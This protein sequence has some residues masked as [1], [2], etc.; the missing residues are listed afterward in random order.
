MTLPVPLAEASNPAE[1]GGKCASL[2]RAI[3]AELPVPGGFALSVGT[4]FAAVEG[5]PETLAA[6]EEVL[7]ELEGPVAVRSSAIGEDDQATSFAGQH[8]TV[9]NVRTPGDLADA[10]AEVYQSAH[11]ASALAYRERMG[12]AGAPR[13]GVV[14]QS[15]VAAECAG[16]LFTHNPATGADERLI[17][18]AWGLG[19]VVVSGLV[20]P[21]SYRIS[22]DGM[23]LERRAGR[24]HMLLRSSDEGGIEEVEVEPERVNAH[25]LDDGSLG[26]LHALAVLCEA[27]Y[28]PR[29][30]IEWAFAEGRLYLLQC[31]AITT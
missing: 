11:S 24:K 14:V 8:A 20:I 30:D 27:E 23:V 2:S 29:L 3:R 18:A 4:V 9:L 31:R 17:E 6:L 25:V 15:L 19:E 21:D 7:A 13:I 1:F 26:E 22:G 10:V 28:G 12:I 16:V 5:R